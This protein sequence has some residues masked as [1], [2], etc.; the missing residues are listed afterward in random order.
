MMTDNK[1]MKITVFY[2]VTVWL[3]RYVTLKPWY[4]FTKLHGTV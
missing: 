3:G 2:K 1:R 4:L